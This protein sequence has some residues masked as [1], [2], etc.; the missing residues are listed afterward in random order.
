V[1]SATERCAHLRR[2]QLRLRVQW[3]LP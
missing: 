3:W 1:L 2:V